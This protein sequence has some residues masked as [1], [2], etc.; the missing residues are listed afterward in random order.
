[1]KLL[2]MFQLE[3][4]VTSNIEQATKEK[5]IPEN[6]LTIVTKE[7]Q[8]D[9]IAA[10]INLQVDGVSKLE[11][12]DNDIA[13]KYKLS[14]KDTELFMDKLKRGGYVM[15]QEMPKHITKQKLN[16][17]KTPSR[18]DEKEKGDFESSLDDHLSAPGFGVDFKDPGTDAQT[19]EDNFN[20]DNHSENPETN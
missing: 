13:E 6:K 7:E 4:E 8:R 17:Q 19:H 12:R 11:L 3:E 9:S 2:S 5:H 1:M 20:P 15:L 18:E 10:L 16:D 14:E